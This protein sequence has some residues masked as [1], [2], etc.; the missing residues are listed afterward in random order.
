MP[1]GS[2]E[3]GQRVEIKN[4]N[5]IRNV[6]RSIEYEIIRHATLLGNNETILSETRTFDAVSGKT[7]G[8]RKKE[9][10]HDYRY[11]PEPDLT[12][13]FL[14]EKYI[15][16]LNNTMPPLP[17]DLFKKYQQELQLSA[18]D[19][20]NITEQK[21]IAL[22]FEEMIS[23]TNNYKSAANWI[24]GNV[25]SYLNQTATTIQQFPINPKNLVAL[26]KLIDENKISNTLASQQ[27]FPAM[28]KSPNQS[29]LEIANEN[30]WI[31]KNDSEELKSIVLTIF[32]NHPDETKRFKNGDKK[33]IGFFMGK[34]MKAS[35][36]TADPKSASIL[37][38]KLIQSM[39]A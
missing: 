2:E 34:I 32:N 23:L 38:N 36:G 33:L 14:T 1:K 29:P 12:P 20:S 6:Q 5:S 25:K 31:S 37:I 7:I 3:F 16:G 21:E 4:L 10:A 18:Y 30:G 19:A 24:M 26:I 9:A 39:N 11:F 8:M 27:L 17:N 35:K 22:Y 13:I 15:E 28:L